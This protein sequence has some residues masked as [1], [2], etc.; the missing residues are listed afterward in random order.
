M[1]DNA[2]LALFTDRDDGLW[3]GMNS[4]LVQIV[5]NNAVTIFDGTNGPTPGTIDGWYRHRDKVYAGS[6]DG[7][8]ELMPPDPAAGTPAAFERIVDT[9]ANVFAFTTLGDH[10]VF[11]GS[12]GLYRLNA[13]R[14][15]ELILPLSQNPPKTI[16]D[17]QLVKNRVYAS[18]Q[19]GL[20]V[21][22]RTGEEFRI[23]GEV[24]DLGTSFFFN[25]EADGDVWLGSYSTG[26]TRVLAA[27]QITD[28]DQ[29]PMERYWRSNGLPE[30]MTWTTVTD[31]SLGTVFFTDAGGMM[32]DE[33][34]R[35]FT[36]DTRYQI[37]GQ[38]GLGLTPSIVTP[39]GSTWTSVFG[40]SAMNAAYPFGRFLPPDA[41]GKVTWQAAQ[42]GALDE[43]G[44][45]GAAVFYV[46]QQ[47]DRTVMWARGYGNHI[48]VELDRLTVDRPVWSALIRNVRR[49]GRSYA[50]AGAD[51]GGSLFSLPFSTSPITF[52]FA[53]PRYDVSGGFTYQ[54]RLVGFDSKWSEWSNIPQISFT[55]I[56]GGPFTLEVRARDAS[57]NIS[58]PATFAFT[59]NPPWFRSP[60]AFVVYGLFVLLT[61]FSTFRWR[62][63]RA[64]RERLRLSSLVEERTIQLAEAKEEAESANQAK[65]TFLANMSHELRTPL[66]GVIGYAQILLKDAQIDDRNR[67]RVRVVA[68]SGEHLLR[69]INEVLDFSKI[70]A[71]QVEL[72]SGTFNLAALLKDIAA[73]QQ[74]KADSK[75][76]QFT[77][78]SE[79]PDGF[80]FVGD[81]QKL[82]Q[83]VDNLLGNAIKFTPAGSVT[84]TVSATDDDCV[85]FAVTDTGVGLSPE[86][87]AQL[88]VPFRQSVSGNPPEPGTG[89]G[90]SISQHLVELMGGKIEVQSAP[91]E[92]STFRFKIPLPQIEAPSD[93]S[94]TATPEI[95]GYD[96]HQRTVMVVDDVLVNRN[97]IDEILTPIGFKVIKMAA[98]ETALAAI[99]ESAEPPDGLIVD[100]RMPGM[101]GLEFSRRIRQ[102]YGDR[103]K[104]VLMSA[105]V[106]AF[107]PQIAFDA[108]CDDFLPKPFREGDLLDR[109][110]RALKIRWQVA[111]DIRGIRKEIDS[112]DL[113]YIELA[114]LAE[115]LRPLVAAYQMDGIR[116]TLAARF[117]AAPPTH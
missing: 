55:N 117:D 69:M 113:D 22:E 33:E 116:H 104:V 62:L 109:L 61:L 39:D 88:F 9:V 81:A 27:H 50:T 90:L 107:D 79:L 19:D 102:T 43:I 6:F 47:S 36:T 83:V 30:D 67:E 64:E 29:I 28:W 57:G 5:H 60:L 76:L 49:D 86:D 15:Y 59:I 78:S 35:R 7:L 94:T 92:G 106:L 71:G 82:R 112:W 52:D 21:L 17:S 108:G 26:F 72:K 3:A 95:V 80:H 100:L 51:I 11:S 44:F 23:L 73:N 32:F 38:T 54:S 16:A 10:L 24:L 105:S 66:N 1:A 53:V 75:S 99:S 37:D 70:E 8:Y 2:I 93:E 31:G 48:R 101:D 91:G 40:E 46:D 42:G 18:G 58:D 63:A 87:Q 13:D 115:T 96:G 25:E 111:A 14:S 110:G 103:P 77:L 65:S 56:E 12:E 41:D 20:T 85:S 114:S 68:N 74:P 34:N 4:G 45:G 98:A 97:L 89:L 84:L